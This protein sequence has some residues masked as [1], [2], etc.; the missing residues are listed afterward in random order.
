MARKDPSQWSEAYRKRIAAQLAKGKTVQEARGHKSGEAKRRRERE[1]R[2][3]ET[4]G[5]LTSGERSTVR[6]FAKE[7]AERIG[8]DYDDISQAMLGFAQSH[9]MDAFK[10]LRATQRELKLKYKRR[11]PAFGQKGRKARYTMIDLATLELMADNAGHA[12]PRWYFYH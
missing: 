3:R 11:D 4:L 7:Q 6:A 2:E 9:G 10:Q 1:H 5:K 8:E 12:E